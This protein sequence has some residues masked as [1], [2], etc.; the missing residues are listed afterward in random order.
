M[1]NCHLFALFEYN[2][3]GLIRRAMVGRVCGEGKNCRL[4]T[5]GVCI[6]KEA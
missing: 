1:W 6:F 3:V 5:V 4:P 2:G